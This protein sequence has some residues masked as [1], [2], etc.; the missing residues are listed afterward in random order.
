MRKVL[1]LVGATLL[2]AGPALAADLSRPPP[3]YKA[4]ALMPVLNW[5]GWY[6]GGNAGWVGTADQNVA[7]T[8]TDTGPGGLGSLLA[9]GAIPASVPTKYSGFLGGG[10][11][12][13]NWQSGTWVFGI[14]A[15]FDGASAKGDT[16][17]VFPG[18][19]GFVPVTTTFHRELDW[20]ATV[21]GRLGVTVAPA[22]LVYTTGG[23]AVGETKIG[24]SF[25]CPTCAPP[26]STEA[27]T[28]NVNSNTAAGWTVGAGAE[29]MFSPNWSVKAEYLYVDLGSHSSTIAYTYGA[30][31]S[32]LTSTVR[33]TDHIVRGGINFH[34]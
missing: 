5:N 26:S 13:Y 19:G 34:F 4:P 2:L 28:A 9:A 15:D 31:T 21:R 7:N 33:D 3:V 29:W 23:L 17:A 20:L 8:G 11:I 30:N 14:E 1:G 27:S 12:G 16:T 18:G 24:N 25:I 32:S 10:Q 6:I 22:F